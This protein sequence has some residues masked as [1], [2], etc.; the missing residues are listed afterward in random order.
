MR[1]GKEDQTDRNQVL[2]SAIEQSLA[3]FFGEER[4]RAIFRYLIKDRLS[5][6]EIAERYAEFRALLKD[7]F[8]PV[9]PIIEKQLDAK[10][11]S[12]MK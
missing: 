5:I 11:G 9:A 2:I 12:I 4:A 3:H 7:A 6:T 1:K 10:I 8:G